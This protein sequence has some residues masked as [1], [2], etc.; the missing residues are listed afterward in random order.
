V[1]T[2][3]DISLVQ[4]IADAPFVLSVT[5]RS[6]RGT[7]RATAVVTILVGGI[8]PS[9]RFYL[10]WLMELNFDFHSYD[11]MLNWFIEREIIRLNEFALEYECRYSSRVQ[12]CRWTD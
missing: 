7:K 8:S 3:K 2:S 12:I 11:H 5:S 6:G 10:P 4:H 1:R 9:S